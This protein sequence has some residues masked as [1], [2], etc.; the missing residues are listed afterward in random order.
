MEIFYVGLTLV[1]MG[2]S[3]VVGLGRGRWG[4]KRHKMLTYTKCGCGHSNSIH[5]QGGHGSCSWE[6]TKKGEHWV[7][8]CLRFTPEEGDI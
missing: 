2:L 4:D 5:R 8:M 6:G 7:C 3:Y 1:L